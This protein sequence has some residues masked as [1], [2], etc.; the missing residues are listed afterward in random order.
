[1]PKTKKTEKKKAGTGPRATAR[2]KQQAEAIYRKLRRQYPDAHCALNH[3]NP[4]QLLASTILSAQCTDVRVNM[5]TP[6]LFKRFPDARAMAGADLA[7]LEQLIRTTGFYR[8]KSK[9]LKGA[10]QAIVQ[11]HDAHVPD[12]MPALTKLPGVARKTANVVLG[13]A[14]GK[15]V[16]VVVDTHVARLSHRMGLTRQK[17]PKKIEQDMMAR[18]RRHSWTLLAHLLIFHGRQVCQARKPRCEQ[19]VVADLC[20]KVGV[21]KKASTPRKPARSKRPRRT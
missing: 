9:S 10:S 1:M 17:D 3:E 21:T 12:T 7:E 2:Q 8:N 18:F 19:C 6:G 11:E 14:F 4:F 16:G 5:V 13:N 20:P 15:N